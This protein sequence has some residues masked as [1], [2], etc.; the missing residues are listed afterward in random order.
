[1]VPMRNLHSPVIASEE[2][3]TTE[4][5]QSLREYYDQYSR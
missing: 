3:I 5:Q 1:M 2:P 4:L